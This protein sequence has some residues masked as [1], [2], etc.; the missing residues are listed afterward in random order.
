[1]SKKTTNKNL[2]E[3][4]FAKFGPAKLYKKD[5]LIIEPGKEPAGVFFIKKGYVRLYTISKEGKEITYN[6]YK[7]GMYFPLIWALNQTHNIYF[8]EAITDTQVLKAPRDEVINV[9]KKNPDLLFILTQNAFSGLEGIT[10]LMDSLLSKNAYRQICSILVTLTVR[11]GKVDGKKMIIDV[12]LTHRVLGTL[13]GLSREAT[14]REL[15]KLSKEKIISLTDHKITILNYKKLQEEF[16][17]NA[18]EHI[19]F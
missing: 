2:D 15:E 4:F 11:F 10:K 19:N 5:Q 6:I 9:L 3:N 8:I 7:P 1:M 17:S 12:P 13:A 18:S 14:S 16:L